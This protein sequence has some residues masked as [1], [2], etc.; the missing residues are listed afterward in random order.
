MQELHDAPVRTNE[1]ALPLMPEKRRPTLASIASLARVS[2]ATVSRALRGHPALSPGTVQRVRRIAERM[3]YRPNPLVSSVMRQFRGTRGAA[4]HGVIG[5]LT[6]GAN[7][8]AWREHL[9]FLG[10]FEG[11][12]SRAEELGFALDE[13]WADQPGLGPAR[14]HEILRARG[15]TGL[16]IGPTAGLPRTPEL[17]WDDFAPVKIGVPYPDLPLP[18]SM[19]N[20]YHAMQRVIERLHARGYRRLGLVLASHQNIKTSAMWLTPFNYHELHARPEERVA[21]LVMS[22]WSEA[23]FARWFKQHRPEVIIG[24]RRELITWLDRLGQ[25]VPEDVGFVHLD[26]ATERGN[27]A[28]IDQRPREIG[29]AALDMVVG[30]LHAN[31]RGLPDTQRLLLID[32]VWVDGPTIRS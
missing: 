10:F 30:R 23:V 9:T 24:L 3:G 5:Y 15:I 13:I 20:Q 29:A 4:V 18:C 31:Q 6:F 1:S 32:G 7:A 26:R 28:G 19:S 8:S 22:T 2:E 21:P 16:I 17:P 12:K 14:L 27:F 25:R 11:A